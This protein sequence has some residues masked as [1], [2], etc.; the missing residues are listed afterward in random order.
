MV[1]AQ[2][3]MDRARAEKVDIIGLSGLITPSLDE[4]VNVASELER[5]GFDLPLLIG[6]AT[7]SRIHTALKIVPHY[8]RAATVHVLDASR[9]VGVVASLLGEGRDAYRRDVEKDYA[10][11]IEKHARSQADKQRLSIAEARKDRFAID[12]TGYQ[13]PKP[14]FLGTRTFNNYPIDEL[15]PYIDWTP[16]FA[17][18][19]MVGTYPL[20][21][22]NPKYGEA[23]RSL[24]NDA[25]AM[26]AEIVAGKWLTANAVIGFW[27][28]SA[29][30]DDILVYADE[31]RNRIKATLFSLRQQM[32]RTGSAR[33]HIALAD[34][35]APKETG[36]ADYIGGFAVSAG[37]GEKAVADRFTRANDDYSKILSQSLADRLAEALAERMHERVRLEFWAYAADEDL[38]NQE[39]IAEK[40]RGIRP[41]PGYPAQ[42]DHTEKRTL[43]ELLDAEKE[44]GIRLTESYAMWPASSVSGLYFSHPDS[45][46]F[47]VGRIGR[48]QI[49]DYAER[50]RWSVAEAERWLAPILG[51]DPDVERAA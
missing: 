29:D 45:H 33:N 7:T 41:A 15:V 32:A 12:W 42:P 40:Y 11:L 28:A 30:G 47:G 1:P 38:S 46:Y 27:P 48:D 44:T 51:Y 20:L 14:T 8:Q 4:M 39:L 36:I 16:F 26:L 22:D 43:F 23:A 2:Q 37:F 49:E 17:A 5:A 50:K 6:G 31:K 3:I 18:W 9:A 34:F 25:Q 19:E 35:V 10:V 24:F 21:L 13:P